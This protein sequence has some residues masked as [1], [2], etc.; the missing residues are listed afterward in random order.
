MMKMRNKIKNSFLT[1]TILLAI[2]GGSAYAMPT[3]GNVTMGDVTNVANPAEIM[4][5]NANSIINWDSFSVGVGEKVTFDTQ[6]FMV[7]NRV[8]GGQESQILGMLSDQGEGKLLLINPNGI[9]LGENAVINAN[10]L[11]LS[12]LT[13]SDTEFQKLLNGKMAEFK[14]IKDGKISI[15]SNA[16]LTLGEALRIYGGKINIA[17]GVEIVSKENK[18]ASVQAFGAVSVKTNATGIAKTTYSQ[19]KNVEID[20]ASMGNFDNSLSNVELRGDNINLNTTDIVVDNKYNNINSKDND[21][22]VSGSNISIKNG[23]LINKTGDIYIVG[24]EKWE[25]DYK[26]KKISTFNVEADIN[27]NII[28]NNS[29]ITSDN[30]E[31]IIIGGDVNLKKSLISSGKDIFIGAIKYYDSKE[32]VKSAKAYD[33]STVSIDNGVTLNSVGKTTIF[34][35]KF[36]IDTLIDGY[37]V[38]SN[39]PFN[40]YLDE[41]NISIN[42]ILQNMK[43][44]LSDDEMIRIKDIL[45]GKMISKQEDIDAIDKFNDWILSNNIAEEGIIYYSLDKSIKLKFNEGFNQEVLTNEELNNIFDEYTGKIK[46]VLSIIKNLTGNEYADV[47]EALFEADE[48]LQ[49][50]TM[51]INPSPKDNINFA[52]KMVNLIDKTVNVIGTL[53]DD[54]LQ[55]LMDD[56]VFVDFIGGAAKTTG[57]LAKT[58]YFTQDIRDGNWK[59]AYDDIPALF[60]EITDAVGDVEKMKNGIKGPKALISGVECGITLAKAGINGLTQLGK[61]VEKYTKDGK[62]TSEDVTAIGMEV[63]LSIIETFSNHGL[64]LGEMVFDKIKNK[65]G[66]QNN[67]MSNAEQAAAGYKMLAKEIVESMESKEGN[68]LEK[69]GAGAGTGAKIVWNSVVELG[70][71]IVS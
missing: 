37:I 40:K 38:Y 16:S 22:F 53:P 63:S 15:G 9:V 30:G 18:N 19:D 5:A 12:T 11:V 27:N 57:I 67:G 44:V 20:C 25:A 60:N 17:D 2:S 45:E 4:T 13:L 21:I 33:D 36:N 3:G 26:D 46:N 32:G 42:D 41:H 1:A 29:V 28:I 39:N 61:S 50:N 10:D 43:N 51:P 54:E 47:G 23:M 66:T 65:Y 48:A 52:D 58:V 59:E 70:K 34:G 71:I 69:I 8:V 62:C 14:E 31:S 6:K 55:K 24:R 56:S 64:G 49:K 7:L 35:S 68:M